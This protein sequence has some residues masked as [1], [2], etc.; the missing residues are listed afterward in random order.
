MHDY[1]NIQWDLLVTIDEIIVPNVSRVLY[2]RNVFY[3]CVIKNVEKLQSFSIND[4]K[5]NA[6]LIS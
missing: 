1:E 4:T 3:H 5:T 2:L 6:V